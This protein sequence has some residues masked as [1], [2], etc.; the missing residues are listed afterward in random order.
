ME[1]D[2]DKIAE[3]KKK[4]QPVIKEFYEPFAANLKIKEKEI[5]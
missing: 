5:R 4:W 3:G 1:E 2:L